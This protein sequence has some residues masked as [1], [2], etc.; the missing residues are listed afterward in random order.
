[1]SKKSQNSWLGIA[2]IVI[3]AYFM[4]NM[5]FDFS[6]NLDG[7]WTLFIIIPSIIALKKDGFKPL[8]VIG[9]GIGVLF[10][11]SARDLIS[12]GTSIKLIIPIALIIW[13]ISILSGGKNIRKRIADSNIEVNSDLPEYS[14]IFSEQRIICSNEVYAGANINAIMGSALLNLKEAYI[15]E[16][17]IT[18]CSAIFGGITISIP[19]N[20]NVS[21]S[22]VPIFGG[23]DNRASKRNIPGAPTIYINATCV[24]GGI[25][26]R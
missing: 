3:G 6:I 7:A 23:I 17:V 16:D 12:F 11:L 1:M 4:L 8:P 18:N 14:A 20:V 19:A 9:L 24:F 26:I 21:V 5:V 25:D 22:C 15:P 10:F 2:L 13:G